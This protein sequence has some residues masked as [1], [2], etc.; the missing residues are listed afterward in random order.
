MST[1]RLDDGQDD[2]DKVPAWGAPG[3]GPQPRRWMP[4]VGGACLIILIIVAMWSAAPPSIATWRPA[5]PPGYND[6]PV[7]SVSAGKP[8]TGAP[9]PASPLSP[10][11]TTP[12]L[13]KTGTLAAPAPSP[14]LLSLV[15]RLGPIV[16]I[17]SMCIDLDGRV[18]INGNRIQIWTCNGTPAQVWAAGIDGTL[19]VLG[20][21]MRIE[22]N[23]IAPGALVE[24]WTCDG[25]PSQEWRFSAGRLVNPGTGLC[26]ESPDDATTDGT[27]PR[28]ASCA[29]NPG[30]HWTAPP[31]V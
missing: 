3:A 14:A 20:L 13:R 24:A 27:R 22:G 9:V 6:A 26:L 29:A 18:A 1:D 5:W 23:S 4:A 12:V 17:G 21:C 8:S 19:Q 25:Q 2:W 11:V 30:Q 10:T 16:G 7:A 31:P 15:G 28:I